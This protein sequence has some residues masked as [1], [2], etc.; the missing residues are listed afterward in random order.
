MALACSPGRAPL[1]GS[2]QGPAL[3]TEATGS[4]GSRGP[5]RRIWWLEANHELPL[6]TG[7]GPRPCPCRCL[8]TSRRQLRPGSEAFL[9]FSPKVSPSLPKARPASL[10]AGSERWK[11]RG[12]SGA[13][14]SFPR[15]RGSQGPATG[16]V[17]EALG[18]AAGA[19]PSDV[20]EATVSPGFPFQRPVLF[21]SFP[22]L[23]SVWLGYCDY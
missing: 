10:S 3:A 13:T 17:P 4:R 8:R 19:R 2:A 1:L 23:S 11:A 15:G 21:I 16:A 14:G 6:E 22:F 18:G 9:A 5:A 7:A 20:P 12:P